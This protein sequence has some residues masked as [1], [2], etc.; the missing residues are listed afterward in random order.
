MQ[1]TSTPKDGD[2]ASYLDG[3]ANQRSNGAPETAGQTS[4]ART[5]ES[6][7]IDQVLEGQE[8]TDEF[9]D[10]FNALNEAPELSDEE[11]ERQALSAP[12]GDGDVLTPE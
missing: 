6:Q 12:G 7:T 10:E 9:I 5:P 4:I 3:V 11:L 1:S 2:F 8:P